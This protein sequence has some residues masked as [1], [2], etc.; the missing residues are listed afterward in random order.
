MS[1]FALGSLA[2]RMALAVLGLSALLAAAPA[3]ADVVFGNLN[4]DN[5]R[6]LGATN[7]DLGDGVSGNTQWLAQGFAT[8]SSTL[9]DLQ[10]VTVGLFGTSV[11][12]VPITVS[13]YG[14][15][16]GNPGAS[17][18]FTSAV[19]Q[20]GNTDKYSFSF[21]GATLQANTTYWVVPNEGSWYFNNGTPAAPIGQNSSG[22]SYVGARESLTLG[23]TPQ[24]A[25]WDV[26][27]SN[28]YSVSVTSV[29]EPS[30]LALASI[31]VVA[32]V[33]LEARRRVRRIVVLRG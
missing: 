29:P 6:P 25:A 9:L 2:R 30:T 32:I 17:P 15:V 12:T 5:S 14:D 16:S 11:G 3:R 26:G 27:G 18:L 19:T 22:Y 24:N 20:V 10:S 31:G 21:T 7:T 28:R 13:I 4:A 1:S 23:A 8:G 33:G